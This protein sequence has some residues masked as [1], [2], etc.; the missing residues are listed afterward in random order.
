[1]LD[2]AITQPVSEFASC[3]QAAFNW[4]QA[5]CSNLLFGRAVSRKTGIHFSARRSKRF[6]TMRLSSQHLVTK[7]PNYH[8]LYEDIKRQP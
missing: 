2:A 5:A 3:E 7:H 8:I 1:M 6:V 4:N